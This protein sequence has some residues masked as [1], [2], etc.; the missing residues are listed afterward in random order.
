MLLRLLFCE[1]LYLVGIFFYSSS[2]GITI[3]I[4]FGHDDSRI[5]VAIFPMGDGSVE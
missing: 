5:T 3:S 1:G 4:F 2:G